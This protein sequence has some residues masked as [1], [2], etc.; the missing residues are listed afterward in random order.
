MDTYTSFPFCLSISFFLFQMSCLY[1]L[2]VLSLLASVGDASSHNETGTFFV[3]RNKV[4]THYSTWILAFTFDLQPYVSHIRALELET[5]KFREVYNE[6]KRLKYSLPD[7]SRDSYMNNSVEYRDAI[8]D[9]C[10][11][12]VTQLESEVSNIK[13]IYASL[14]SLADK[15]PYEYK[16][17]NDRTKRSLLPF[18]GKILHWLFGVSTDSQ[19]NKLK[20]TIADLSNSQNRVIHA[21]RESVSL[22]NATHQDV[23]ENRYVINKLVNA[24]HTLRKDVKNLFVILHFALEPDLVYLHTVALLNDITFIVSSTLRSVYLY[25]NELSNQIY[26]SIEGNLSSFVIDPLKLSA[27]LKQIKRSLPDD[28]NMP[29]SF[30]TSGFV[31]YYKYLP[32]M[33]VPDKNKFHVVTAIP[34]VSKNMYFDIYEAVSIPVPNEKVSFSL[35]YKLESKYLALSSDGNYYTLFR[36]TDEIPCLGTPFCKFNTP[37]YRVHFAPNCLISLFELSATWIVQHCT[38]V[39]WNNTNVPIVKQLTEN[40]YALSTS[41]NLE[42]EKLCNGSAKTINLKPGIHYLN[43]E[44]GCSIKT[45]Y[46]YIPTY[47]AGKSDIQSSV[48]MSDVPKFSIPKM[49]PE[50]PKPMTK[51]TE[52]DAIMDIKYLGPIANLPLSHIEQ[53]L[54]AHSK[55]SNLKLYWELFL[56]KLLTYFLY[57]LIIV[58]AVM[59]CFYKKQKLRK[60]VFRNAK[61]P[62]AETVIQQPAADET[63]FS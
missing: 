54:E 30:K 22:I 28:L 39:F 48:K 15:T 8:V 4:H 25:L 63:N 11:K 51:D 3:H 31:D 33:L 27:L 5:A 6:L 38:K 47:T 10:G 1:S 62:V 23:K 40:E 34:I 14:S 24:T 43:V 36:P 12:Q 20:A 29:Y 52:N 50:K 19:F 21:F 13:R 26:Q 37:L 2:L 42:L 49:W 32:T 17:T 35:S 44:V 41:T 16:N 18:G 45:K 55:K 7:A 46:F 58:A 53:I 59:F 9:L 61:P 57:L 56:H 60:C